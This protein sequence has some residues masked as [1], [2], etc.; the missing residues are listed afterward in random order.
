[1]KA[2]AHFW[3][4][5]AE[6]FLERKMFRT[7]FIEKIKTHALYSVTFSRKSYRLWETVEKYGRP[8][9]ATHSNNAAHAHRMLDN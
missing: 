4:C 9:Q 6:F 1:M 3:S 8:G 5:L 2:T 7:K